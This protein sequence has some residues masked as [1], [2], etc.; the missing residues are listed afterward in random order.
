MKKNVYKNIYNYLFNNSKW[1]CWSNIWWIYS[2]TLLNVYWIF[3]PRQIQFWILCSRSMFLSKII[4]IFGKDPWLHLL[5][6][7][8]GSC[9][10]FHFWRGGKGLPYTFVNWIGTDEQPGLLFLYLSGNLPNYSSHFLQ[11]IKTMSFTIFHVLGNIMHSFHCI[12]WKKKRSK[13]LLPYSVMATFSKLT[14]CKILLYIGW[15]LSYN[16]VSF[17]IHTFYKRR[18]EKEMLPS[19]LL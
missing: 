17:H 7:K 18:L 5:G 6:N 10:C 14:F 1:K 9:N 12:E 3:A 2:L 4:L 11:K 8:E 16:S 15:S 19:Y 13:R